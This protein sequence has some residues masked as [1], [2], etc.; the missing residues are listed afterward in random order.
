MLQ[1]GGLTP[2]EALRCATLYGAQYL[3]LDGDVGSIEPG[4]LAD[5]AIMD[6]NPLDDIRNSESV[7]YVMANGVLY[8]ASNMDEVYPER[9]TRP[10]FFWERRLDGSLVGTEP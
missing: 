6:K 5:F 3:G 7:S 10:P 4:K 1:Q 8:D 2:L 9:R